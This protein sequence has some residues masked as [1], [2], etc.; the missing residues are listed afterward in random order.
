[1]GHQEALVQ[2]VGLNRTGEAWEKHQVRIR[3]WIRP[4]CAAR[5]SLCLQG[6][7][8]T[9]SSSWQGKEHC[10]SVNGEGLCWRGREDVSLLLNPQT[11]CS[12]LVQPLQ[13]T[14]REPRG[15]GASSFMKSVSPV[16]LGLLDCHVQCFPWLLIP[17]LA[18]GC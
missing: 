17:V 12:R 3:G 9:P 18:P 4:C 15:P 2:H 14:S 10:S 1:M 13:A 5:A 7:P 8:H 11:L 6:D 16:P